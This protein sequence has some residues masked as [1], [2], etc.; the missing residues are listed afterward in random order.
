M[1]DGH[2]DPATDAFASLSAGAPTGADPGG[3]GVVGGEPVPTLATG[4]AL[5]PADAV[6]PLLDALRAEVGGVV[7]AANNPL[8]VIAGNAQLLIELARAGGLDAAFARPLE[9]I[10]AAG[11][12]LADALARLASVR[13]RLADAVGGADRIG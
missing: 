8:T 2:T 7:H 1:Q 10:E 6:G 12:Q 4:D 13:Q 9:D 11:Q 5:V 3:D